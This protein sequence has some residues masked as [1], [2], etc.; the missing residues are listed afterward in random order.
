MIFTYLEHNSFKHEHWKLFVKMLLKKSQR[1]KKMLGETNY[2]IQFYNIYSKNEK[3]NL[4][5]SRGT[6]FLLNIPCSILQ[7]GLQMSI[8][9]E[10]SYNTCNWTWITN[11]ATSLV[12]TSNKCIWELCKLYLLTLVEFAEGETCL[13]MVRTFQ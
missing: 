12:Q 1:N 13:S 7:K 5:S 9:D 4:F 6:I 10:T 2:F 3:E 11:L 8:S